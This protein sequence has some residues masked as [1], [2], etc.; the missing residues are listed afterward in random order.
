METTLP[1][2]RL[3]ELSLEMF[4]KSLDCTSYEQKRKIKDM[5]LAELLL[6]NKTVTIQKF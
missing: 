4:A 6:A 2:M 5:F 3:Q 1:S